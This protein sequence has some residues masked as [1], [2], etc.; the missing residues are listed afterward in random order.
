MKTARLCVLAFAA[1]LTAA[2]ALRAQEVLL[3]YSSWLPAQ[4]HVNVEV[5]YPWFEQ[6]EEVTEGRVKVHTLPK[7][8]GSAA[9]QFDVVRDGLAD[10]SFIV[11]GY[12]PG[13]F[14]LTEMGEMSWVGDNPSVFGPLFWDVYQEYM[15]EHDEYAGTK[16]MTLITNAPG[17]IATTEKKLESMEDLAGLKLRSAGPYATALTEEIGA[18][19]VLKPAPETYELLTTGVLD[20]TLIQPETMINFNAVGPSKYFTVIPGGLFAA[21]LAIIMNKASFD[22]LSEADQQAIMEISGRELAQELA[23]DYQNATDDAMRVMAEE[24]SLTIVT[25]DDA[26][27]SQIEEVVMPLEEEWVTRAAEYGLEN[28]MEVLSEFRRRVSEAEASMSN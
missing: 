22:G 15:A 26:M 23:D 12:T 21:P 8:V 11:P 16:L 28:P 25:A 20:G 3:R 17:Y 24:P 14:P 9:S 4:H 2:P 6:I 19:P 18:V 27:V 5:M 7:V 13:R 1:A 10:I